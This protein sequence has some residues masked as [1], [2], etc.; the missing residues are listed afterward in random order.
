MR[1]SMKV[2]VAATGAVV[3]ASPAMASNWRTAPVPLSAN[4]TWGLGYRGY[5]HQRPHEHGYGRGY[6]A[7]YAPQAA[8]PA[9]GAG[10]G[11]G[12]RPQ[13]LDCVHV[14]FPQCGCGG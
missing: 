14:T 8:Q 9:P 13:I 2:I 6:G 4:T 10:M 1:T 7:A 3:L 12:V 11:G 5:A